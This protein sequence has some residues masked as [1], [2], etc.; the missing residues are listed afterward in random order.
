MRNFR[1]RLRSMG[2]QQAMELPLIPG[3]DPDAIKAII[4]KIITIK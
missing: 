1:E 2:F 3:P 4:G